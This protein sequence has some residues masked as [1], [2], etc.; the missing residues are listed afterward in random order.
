QT[1]GAA[2]GLAG[3][4]CAWRHYRTELECATIPAFKASASAPSKQVLPSSAVGMA[5]ASSEPFP[6]TPMQKSPSDFRL[7]SSLALLHEGYQF[8]IHRYR[9]GTNHCPDA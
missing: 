8:G 2:R 5:I 6:E 3:M 7:G 4:R 9:Y 1:G